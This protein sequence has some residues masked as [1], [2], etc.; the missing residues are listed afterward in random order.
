MEHAK[1]MYYL[2]EPLYYYCD[3]QSSATRS[4][5]SLYSDHDTVKYLDSYRK[6]LSD[7]R[8]SQHSVDII[9]GVMFEIAVDFRR[10]EYQGRHHGG[11]ILIKNLEADIKRFRK[12]YYYCNEFSMKRKV[13]WSVKL[14]VPKLGLQRK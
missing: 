11:P 14:F 6:I 4:I 12:C 13:K 7:H 9:Q 3:N 10:F 2:A 8:L 1:K 5:D